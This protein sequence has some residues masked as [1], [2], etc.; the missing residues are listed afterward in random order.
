MTNNLS[1]YMFQPQVSQLSAAA[2]VDPDLAVEV[3]LKLAG[4]TYRS[5]ARD[6]FLHA[7][8]H[9]MVDVFWYFMIYCDVLWMCVW[10]RGQSRFWWQWII[11]VATF[12]IYI[13]ATFCQ[14]T[15]KLC[16]FR[17]YACSVI[18]GG[19]LWFSVRS[20]PSA[21]NPNSL[22]SEP[23]LTIR[24]GTRPDGN[25]EATEVLDEKARLDSLSGLGYQWNIAKWMWIDMIS[26]S[27][28]GIL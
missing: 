18:F 19:F 13:F 5:M 4:F 14:A 28:T 8:F 25:M 10:H 15:D 2:Q 24:L 12:L 22:W 6:F 9:F 23:Y 3:V 20:Q 11:D 7:L 1:N 27:P 16:T 21:W 26:A 17:V